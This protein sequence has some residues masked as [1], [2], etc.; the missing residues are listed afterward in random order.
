MKNSRV[1]T[2]LLIL[3]GVLILS[4]LLWLFII[5]NK[6]DK[7]V[8]IPPCPLPPIDSIAPQFHQN[9]IISGEILSSNMIMVNYNTPIGSNPKKEKNWIGLWEGKTIPQGNLIKLDSI[10]DSTNVA[11]LFLDSLTIKA[12]DYVIGYGVGKDS[13]SFQIISTLSFGAHLPLMTAGNPD[14]TAIQI[15]ETGSNYLS[16]LLHSPTGK[17]LFSHGEQI[18]IKYENTYPTSPEFSIPDTAQNFYSSLN[19]KDTI[20]ANNIVQV[21]N[22]L[23]IIKNYPTRQHEWY[24]MI[25]LVP[26]TT[27]AATC[28]FRVNHKTSYLLNQ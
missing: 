9:T 11:S 17:P 15:L 23:F 26:D 1:A 14:P 19:F 16:F 13:S 10:L 2:V 3:L 20:P 7:P 18:I 24:T 21:D 28:T 27:I 8:P 22:E 25:Y 4:S 12:I 5:I 6:P